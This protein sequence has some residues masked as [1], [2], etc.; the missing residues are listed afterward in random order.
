[1]AKVYVCDGMTIEIGAQIV[2]IRRGDKSITP[3]EKRKI[4]PV[5]A[6][7][8]CA[9]EFWNNRYFKKHTKARCGVKIAEMATRIFGLEQVI[10]L[11]KKYIEPYLPQIIEALQHVY[12]PH[13][14]FTVN[15]GFCLGVVTTWIGK[16]IRQRFTKTLKGAA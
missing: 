12:W 13:L 9:N 3:I 10:S 6:A 4:G 11:L 16:K 1:M 14:F 2:S 7:K 8:R 5:T 15:V